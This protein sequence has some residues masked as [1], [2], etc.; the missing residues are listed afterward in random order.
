MYGRTDRQTD[1]TEL[2]VENCAPLGYYAA[3]NAI[4]LL[5]FRDNLSFPFK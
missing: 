3:S 5:T 4:F 2:I 1:M